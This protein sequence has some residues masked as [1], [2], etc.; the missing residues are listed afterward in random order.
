MFS[1]NGDVISLKLLTPL[2]DIPLYSF[3]RPVNDR[4]AVD[5]Y[6]PFTTV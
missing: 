5:F 3:R 6:D 1:T 2:F 4:I